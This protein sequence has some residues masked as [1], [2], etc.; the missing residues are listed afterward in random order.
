MESASGLFRFAQSFIPKARGPVRCD[1]AQAP[2]PATEEPSPIP[3]MPAPIAPEDAPPVQFE[4]FGKEWQQISQQDNFDGFRIEGGKPV[5]KH[6]Q[7]SHLLFLGTQMRE[8]GYIY[9]FGPTFQSEDQRTVL[10][11]RCGL[12]GGNNGRWIQKVGTN[13]ELKVSSSSHL[14][15]Q[16]RNMHDAQ[17]DYNGG[18]R[19]WSAKL[20]WQG[21]YILGGNFTQRL[22][23]TLQV[24][25]ELTAAFF[26]GQ[27]SPFGSVGLRWAQ[28]KDSVCAMANKMPVNDSI[29]ARVSYVR[30][31]SERLTLGTEY[32][33]VAPSKESG[34]Q[35]AYEY[36]FRQS[37]IQGLV[38]TEGKVSCF[39]QDYQGFGASGMID[40][41]RGDYKF[42]MMFQVLPPQE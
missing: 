14:K 30:K 18:S 6:L 9:Q 35:L 40:Y 1:D 4:M 8:T 5:T 19:T 39:V 2:P 33:L 37:R 27:I 34:L 23:P 25:G 22:M 31:I 24:G 29:E 42:G 20:A 15:Q 38:D 32:K 12:D 11:A 13:H 26:N 28:G 21:A 41:V 17:F 3:A 16:E 10:V 36:A 7:A